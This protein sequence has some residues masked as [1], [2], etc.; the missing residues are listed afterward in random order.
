MTRNSYTIQETIK[1]LGI[2]DSTVRRMLTAGVLKE[3][4]RDARGRVLIDAQSVDAAAVALGR[5][6][7]TGSE[8]RREIAPTLNGLAEMVSAL[9]QSIQEKDNRM[10]RLAEELG[11][12]RAEARRLPIVER[13]LEETRD[14]LDEARREISELKAA[15]LAFA[16]AGDEVTKQDDISSTRARLRRLLGLD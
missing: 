1:A 13:E 6:A 12:A 16:H 2:S 8:V 14:E 3:A 7:L 15:L 5:T 4:G 11:E 10:I 9:H